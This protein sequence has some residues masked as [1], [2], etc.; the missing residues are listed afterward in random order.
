MTVTPGVDDTPTSTRHVF[1]MI[2]AWSAGP[3]PAPAG[4]P[5]RQPEV[6][7]AEAMK[8][9]L[10]YGWQPQVMA[11]DGR[12]KNHHVLRI[13]HSHWPRAALGDNLRESIDEG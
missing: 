6:V 13:A 2:L 8:P 11:V 7:M 9:F 5:G 10:D 4:H 3:P 1:D 12:L